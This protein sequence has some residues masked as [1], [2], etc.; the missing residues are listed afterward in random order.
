[1]LT[2]PEVYE[3]YYSGAHFGAPL[4]AYGRVSL[5]VANAGKNAVIIWQAGTLLQ[6]SEPGGAW[7]PV[8]GATAPTYNV[9]PGAGAK[10]YRAHL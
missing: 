1:V 10:F 9:T 2:Q 4:D 5:A 6:A 3:I 7:T 8:P